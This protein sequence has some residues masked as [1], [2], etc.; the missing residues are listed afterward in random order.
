LDQA[1][2]FPPQAQIFTKDKLSWMQLRDIPAYDEYYNF[3]ETLSTESLK[4]WKATEI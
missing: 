2:E 3:N 1:D 4:R